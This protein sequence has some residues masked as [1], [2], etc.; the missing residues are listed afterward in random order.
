MR[1]GFLSNQI[2]NRGT[3]NALFDY[4]H[5]NEEILGNKSYIFTPRF[6]NADDL[7]F[8]R[9]NDRFVD[10]VE[11]VGYLFSRPELYKLDV[12]YHIQYGNE[13]VAHLPGAKYV[14]HAVFDASQPHGDR[15]ATISKWMG[16]RYGVPYVPH[17]VEVSL[18]LGYTQGFN[19]I[20]SELGIPENAFV[21]GRYGGRDTF[22]VPFV[23]NAI[24]RV[25][26]SRSDVYFIFMNTD[27]PDK[28]KSLERVLEVPPTADPIHKSRFIVACDAMLHARIRGETFGLAVAEFAASARP[29]ITYDLSPERAHLELLGRFALRYS[30]E[31]SLIEILMGYRTHRS[32]VVGNYFD[33]TP[34]KVMKKFKEVFLD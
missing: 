24:E 3:G 11:S 29:I 12:L 26:N 15:F 6:D 22:D 23:W 28:Y 19:N 34:E 25:H 5:Y 20:R 16:E 9:L 10:G 4:A 31:E 7:M 8:K 1:V 14:V 32:L 18:D 33:F 21:F 2:D 30:N 13:G 17:I 27:I